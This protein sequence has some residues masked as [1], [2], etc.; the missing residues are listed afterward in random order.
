MICSSY[1]MTLEDLEYSAQVY[2]YT[3][4]VLPMFCSFWRL[5]AAG[6]SSVV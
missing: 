1:H 3:F 2:N 5:K 6:T 4:L